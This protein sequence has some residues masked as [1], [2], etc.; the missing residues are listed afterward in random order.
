MRDASFNGEATEKWRPSKLPIR[1]AP[2][3]AHSIL[4]GTSSAS[5]K[6]CS[7]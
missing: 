5:R 6:A 7:Q 4:E 2:A 3:P 1:A